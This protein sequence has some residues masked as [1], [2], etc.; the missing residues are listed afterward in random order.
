MSKRTYAASD[1]ALLKVSHPLPNPY[2]HN[3]WYKKWGRFRAADGITSQTNPTP[4][5]PA[6]PLFLSAT[7]VSRLRQ[8]QARS[9]VLSSAGSLAIRVRL[10]WFPNS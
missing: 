1:T 6:P 10:A 2:S 5:A 8:S 4:L 3:P 7:P 9:S